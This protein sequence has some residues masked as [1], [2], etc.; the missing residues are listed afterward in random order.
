MN[1]PNGWE[2]YEVAMRI[3]KRER[4]KGKGRKMGCFVVG[5]RQTKSL[6]QLEIAKKASE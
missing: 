1:L 4:R 6:D 5:G 3:L 2:K